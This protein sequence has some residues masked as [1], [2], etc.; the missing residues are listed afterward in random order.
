M[1]RRSDIERY[2]KMQCDILKTAYENPSNYPRSAGA[3]RSV[4]ECINQY[5]DLGPLKPP[6]PAPVPSATQSS[7]PKPRYDLGGPE[8]AA[9][10]ED[11]EN[12]IAQL[13]AQGKWMPDFDKATRAGLR[14]SVIMAC[15]GVDR[16]S[17]AHTST[18]YGRALY[19]KGKAAL[20]K[21]DLD[22]AIAQLTTA[23]ADDPKNPFPYIRRGE[24]YERKGD[25]AE[26]ISDYRT[27]LKLVDAESGAEYAAKIRKLEKTNGRR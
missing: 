19:A 8:E 7:L 21:G 23:V 11:C 13:E 1:N 17:A 24:A 22:T 26:A 27:V 20:D 14:D 3:E 5:P 18:A 6:P 10:R 15:V 12:G 4:Q 9:A 2:V 16:F 25:A